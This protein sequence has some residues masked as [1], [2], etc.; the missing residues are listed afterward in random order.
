MIFMRFC[1]RLMKTKSPPR[2]M[3]MPAAPKL[4]SITPHRPSK[5]L[6]MSVGRVHR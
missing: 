4:V 3:F 1:L 2:V 6:R 5:L